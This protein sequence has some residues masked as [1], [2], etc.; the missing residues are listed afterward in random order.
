MCQTFITVHEDD[1]RHFKALAASKGLPMTLMF[2]QLIKDQCLPHT[3][4]LANNDLVTV[5]LAALKAD[6]SLGPVVA[7]LLSVN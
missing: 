3:K 6:G 4:T 1:K 5:A 7:R 2:R